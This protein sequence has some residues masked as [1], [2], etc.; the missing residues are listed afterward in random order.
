MRNFWGL[1]QGQAWVSLAQTIKNLPAIQETWVRS[2]G[3]EDLLGEGNSNPLQYSCLGNPMG[4]GAWQWQATVHGVTVRNDWVTNT[5]L[6]GRVDKVQ[7]VCRACTLLL[8]WPQVFSWWASW[9][10]QNVTFSE[11]KNTDIFHSGL[12]SS[13]KQLKDTVTCIPWGGT[14][15]L[16]RACVLSCFSRVWL[17]VTP[18]ECSLPGFSVHGILQ[19]RIP[20]WVAVAFFRGSSWP[21]IAPASLMS[22]EF[23][24]W[25]LHC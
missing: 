17:L 6:K 4:R 19:A 23:G 9:G 11:M 20:G 14:R 3:W 21:R 13:I 12:F 16:P 1:V 7:G 8:L 18:M 25:V 15:T 2:L 5:L 22:P 24:R 10:Y